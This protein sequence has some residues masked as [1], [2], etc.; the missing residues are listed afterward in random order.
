VTLVT[1]RSRFVY[2]LTNI[3]LKAN[4]ATLSKTLLGK[5]SIRHLAGIFGNFLMFYAFLSMNIILH[6]FIFK[7][8][9]LP[10]GNYPIILHLHSSLS[11]TPSAISTSASMKIFSPFENTL[12]ILSDST[13]SPFILNSL[14][15]KHELNSNLSIQSS[16]NPVFSSHIAY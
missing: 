10:N 1:K 11:G 15:S 12:L 3:T 14:I 16:I 2:F 6:P 8:F 7:G 4:L 13:S 9:R 5:I